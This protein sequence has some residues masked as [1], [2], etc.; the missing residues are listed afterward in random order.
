M[1]QWAVQTCHERKQVEEHKPNREAIF[2]EKK[3]GLQW[4]FAGVCSTR[5]RHATTHVLSLDNARQTNTTAA[6]RSYGQACVVVMHGQSNLTQP[7]HS[8]HS[9]QEALDVSTSSCSSSNEFSR[10]K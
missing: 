10:A 2:V 4:V 3:Q 8:G 7:R 9:S 5:H 1:V 6:V